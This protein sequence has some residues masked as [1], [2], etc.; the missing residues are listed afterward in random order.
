MSIV[1]LG[2]GPVKLSGGGFYI[3]RS[4]HFSQGLMRDKNLMV[5]HSIVAG[6]KGRRQQVEWEREGGE[7][8]GIGWPQGDVQG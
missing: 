4:N 8:V 2:G 5:N 3:V 6:L 7:R 1:L